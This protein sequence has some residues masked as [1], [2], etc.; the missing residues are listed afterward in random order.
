MTKEIFMGRSLDAFDR[1]VAQ[2]MIIAI[3]SLSTTYFS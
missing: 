2:T 1:E 3:Y